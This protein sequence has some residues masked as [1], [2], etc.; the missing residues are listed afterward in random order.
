[1]I[2]LSCCDLVPMNV[3][4]STHPVR[5]N[6][7]YAQADHPDNHFEQLYHPDAYVLWLHK[8]LAKITLRAAQALN[9]S[10]GWVC[11]LIDGL[12][13]VEAQREMQKFGYPEGMIAPPGKGGHPKAM[14]IDIHPRDGNGEYIDMGTPF[15]KFV[16]DFDIE[17][18][19]AARDITDFGHDL[20]RNAQI[21]EN[22]Q[23]LENAMTKAATHFG[24]EL[25]PLSTEWWDFRFTK[26]YTDQFVPLSEED[27]RPEQR[28]INPDLDE[29]ERVLMR[30]KQTFIQKVQ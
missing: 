4:E 11:E 25:L 30:Q 8:D 3:F 21:V 9:D 17:V 16:R 7:I 26:D 20:E 19:Y 29:L 18:N 15:D 27:L 23:R 5:V 14:A 10:Y 13:P 2:K 28:L 24:F 1:M 22:R 6:L 12:R